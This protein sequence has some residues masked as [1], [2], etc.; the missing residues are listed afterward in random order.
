MTYDLA[1]LGYT[2]CERIRES[3]FVCGEFGMITKLMAMGFEW[4]REV[5]VGLPGPQHR[6]DLC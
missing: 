3:V 1:T 6:Q 4:P 2:I 5:A